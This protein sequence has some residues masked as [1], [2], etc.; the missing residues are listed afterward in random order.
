MDASE[1][2]GHVER[3]IADTVRDRD[4]LAEAIVGL[5]AEIIRLQS[6]AEVVAR[7]TSWFS[8][9]RGSDDS[10]TPASQGN[11]HDNDTVI[12]WPGG[13]GFDAPIK[14]KKLRARSRAKLAAASW[15]LGALRKLVSDNDVLT[16]TLGAEM[17]F[18]GAVQSLCA[19]FE[20]EL[21]ALTK[22]IE[23]VAEIPED[24]RTPPHLVTWSK[25]A[26]ATS[27]FDIDLAS[28]LSI[29]DAL[30]GEHSEEPHGWLAQLLLLKRRLALH[31]FLVEIDDPD[32]GNSSLRID[33]PGRG[34]LPLVEYL[35]EV[36][37]LA[38]ELLETI[39]HDIT[40]A[41]HGRLYIAAIDEVR[42]RA[43]QGIGDLLSATFL[44]EVENL[45]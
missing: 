34:P 8:P 11:A 21:C 2:L 39:E 16:R 43:E 41:K 7:L 35:Q 26:A 1:L 22:A 24:R 13:P 31:D 38:E 32:S 42:A 5:D 10:L 40:D 15:Y 28:S 23:K 4:R 29:S 45:K 30:V 18:D 6:D 3:R 19:A 9:Q 20:S 36:H 27:V 44:P 25:L 12:S 37:D 33:V 17:A 14:T